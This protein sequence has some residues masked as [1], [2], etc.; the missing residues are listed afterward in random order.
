VDQ[1]G[2]RLQPPQALPVRGDRA[3]EVEELQVAQPAV[4]GAQVVERRAA[5]EI[6]ALDQQHALPARSALQREQDPVDPA[7]DHHRI[8]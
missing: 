5:A 2:E 4:D 7:A 6:V 8:K 1:V 3:L